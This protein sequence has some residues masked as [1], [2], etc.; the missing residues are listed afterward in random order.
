MN[1][2]MF[3]TG[4]SSGDWQRHEP[5]VVWDGKLRRDMPSGLIEKNERV[6]ARRDRKRDFRKMEGH[7]LGVAGGQDEP[8]AFSLGRTDRPEDIGPIVA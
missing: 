1:C 2:Q 3:S 8:G 4:L 7:G 5:D 6:S